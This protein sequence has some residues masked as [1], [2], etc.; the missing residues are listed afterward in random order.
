MTLGDEE[1]PFGGPP[2]DPS[3]RVWRHPSE[4][5]AAAA[6]AARHAEEERK[7]TPRWSPWSFAIG[8]ATGVA[9]CLGLF[10]I[11]ALSTGGDRLQDS[12]DLIVGPNRE[13]AANLV[14]ALDAAQSLRPEEAASIPVM[15]APAASLPATSMPATSTP[16]T[17]A[18]GVETAPT[19]TTALTTPSTTATTLV[20]AT[21]SSANRRHSPSDGVFAIVS[22]DGANNVLANAV[23]VDGLLLTSASAIGDQDELS[24]RL[25]SGQRTPVSL[26]GIDRYT[27][28]AVL[29]FPDQPADDNADEPPLPALRTVSTSPDLATPGAGANI[30]LIGS[31]NGEMLTIDG[32]LVAVGQRAT[33]SDGH[34]VIGALT[35]TA[36]VQTGLAGSALIDAQ[37]NTFAIVID[38][39]GLLAT[40]IPLGDAV[41]IGHALVEMGRPSANWLGVQAN[42]EDEGLRLTH[43]SDQSPA[44]IAGLE[45]DDLVAS[46]NDREVNSMA[47]LIEQLR[48]ASVGDVLHVQVSR[49]G[50]PW[51]CEIVVGILTPTEQ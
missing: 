28:M 40:A 36:R 38:G 23:A 21:S 39:P 3:L 24:V 41:T 16:A 22:S 14:G 5:A 46:I 6:A 37:G 26:V 17:S 13:P 4:V 44:S 34:E 42:A 51:S 19:A 10:G 15:S 43:V 35:T 33:T 25:D 45:A 50:E 29:A 18:P 20:E 11:A 49:S 48:A 30:A 1:V 47:D 2:P 32:A 7:G 8:G 31:V 27:D 12:D 9:L